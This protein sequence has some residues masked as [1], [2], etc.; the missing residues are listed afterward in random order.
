M[1]T[2]PLNLTFRL[3]QVK[4]STAVSDYQYAFQIFSMWTVW[5]N[6]NS[7]NIF[8]MLMT[9]RLLDKCAAVGSGAL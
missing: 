3:R 4:F 6:A 7:W 2:F 9:F 5:I 8:G 1:E